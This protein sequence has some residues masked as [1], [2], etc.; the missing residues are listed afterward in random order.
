MQL[1]ASLALDKNGMDLLQANLPA[2]LEPSVSCHSSKRRSSA[3][4]AFNP[5]GLVSRFRSRPD[6]KQ[7]RIHS[8]ARQ[9]ST[10]PAAERDMPSPVDF[11][12]SLGTDKVAHS[13]KARNRL[14]AM[15]A[16][17]VCADPTGGSPAPPSM[18]MSNR[19][20]VQSLYNGL[21]DDTQARTSFRI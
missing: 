7:C 11:I 17:P 5:K 16:W 12:R 19:S 21:Y 3:T 15:L 20:G 14:F 1:R 18:R 13:G 4:D 10:S 9:T 6:A 8:T 2:R